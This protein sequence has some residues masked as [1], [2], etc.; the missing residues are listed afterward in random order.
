FLFTAPGPKMVWQFGEVGYD[1]SIDVNGRTG[2]KP[3]HWEYNNDPQRHKLY[4]TF[5]KLISMKINNP[6]FA[7]SNITYSSSGSI[8]TASLTGA[9]GTNV[10]VAGNF[11]VNSQ[12][13]TIAFPSAGTWYDYMS[14]TTVNVTTPFATTYAPGEY[15]IYSSKAL[16]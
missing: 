12:A 4:A 11:D 13:A 7:T 10:V 15:H 14:G 9:D 6:V 16:K 2:E 8:K 5:S 1:I 3:L